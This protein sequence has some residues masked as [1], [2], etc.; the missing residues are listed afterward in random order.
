MSGGKSDLRIPRKLR[1]YIQICL[2]I[3]IG[4]TNMNCAKKS[5]SNLDSIVFFGDSITELG[6]QPTGYVTLIEQ[7]LH[8][9]YPDLRIIGAGISGNRVPDLIARFE[10]D[11][12]DHNPT[13]VIIYI[14]INDVWH[15]ILPGHAGTPK[16]E[17][18]AGL[19]EM[20]DRLRNDEVRIILCTPSVVGEKS[21]GSNPLDPKLDAYAD[22]SRQLAQEK[23]IELCDLRT[24]FLDYLEQH[25][26]AQ[27]STGILTYD[28]VHLSD[29][30]N[31]L[32]AQTLLAQLR[33]LSPADE[34]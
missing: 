17:F 6:I 16:D 14:G 22:I 28:G 29:T 34:F 7:V 4:S 24:V 5:L 3:V 26:P 30:G 15:S 18:R 8:R 23:E 20:I 27:K 10:Q 12:L 1:L 19:S 32:V 25:N 13:I 33:S 31:R 9:D 11:V 2:L 21:D